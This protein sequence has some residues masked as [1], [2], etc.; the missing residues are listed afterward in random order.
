M[1]KTIL[2]LPL[3]ILF[4]GLF[5]FLFMGVWEFTQSPFFEDISQDLNDIILFRLHCTLG[6]VIILFEIAAVL[7]LIRWTWKWILHPKL[8][9]Y[10]LFTLMGITYTAFSEYV[11]VY[12]RGSW[13]YSDMMP[14]LPLIEV[15]VIPLIQWLV[16]PSIIL[17]I[18]SRQV[19]GYR[20]QDS[21]V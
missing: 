2:L 7:F 1:K 19:K 15:G 4:L 21:D 8:G 10:L 3:A 12:V 13:G 11:N 20:I 5:G 16:L 9:D 6:D 17:T 18:T 14:I